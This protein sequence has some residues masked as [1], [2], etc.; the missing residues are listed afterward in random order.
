[1]KILILLK[2]PCGGLY[3]ILTKKNAIYNVG[4]GIPDAPSSVINEFE[5]RVRDAAPY[6]FLLDTDTSIKAEIIEPE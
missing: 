5:R 3:A 1:L 4:R 6:I 2:T